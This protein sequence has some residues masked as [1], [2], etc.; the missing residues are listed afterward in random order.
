MPIFPQD[1]TFST[2]ADGGDLVVDDIVVGLRNGLNTRFQF[3]GEPGTYLPL[4]GGTMAGAIDMNGNIITGLPAPVSATDAVNKAYADSL[5]AGAAM[6]KVDDTNVT[7]TLGGTPLTSLLHAVSLTLGWAGQLSFAR[8]G[9]NA[10][11]TAS[12]GGIL[13]STA[14]AAAILAGTATARQML[15]SG[16]TAAPAWSTATWPATTTANAILFSSATNIVSEI[17]SAA[18]GVLITSAGSVPSISQTLPSAVQTNI[19]ALGAQSQALN[20]NSHLINNVTDPVSAQDAATKNY[21]DK[22]ALNGT[23]VYAATTTNLTVTQSGAGVGATLTN[24]GAQATF[25][26]DGVNPPVGS[27]VLIKNLAAPANEGIYT[28]TSV[29]SGSTNWVLTR[30]TSYDT[31]T[32]INNTGLIIIQNGSTLAGTAWYNATTIVTVDTTAFSYSQF[33]NIIFPVSLAQGGTGASLTASNG[34]IFYSTASAGAILAGTATAGK[35][36]Q[37]GATAA[38]SWST[39]T[40]PSA[41]GTSGK[42]LASDGTNIVYSTA[43]FPVVGGAAGNVLISNGTNYV[44]ST[45]LWPNTV[46]T[47]GT[48]IKSNGTNNVY[49]TSTYSDSYAASALLYAS[50]ANTVVGLATA[51]NGTLVT[52]GSGVPSISSTLP[53]AVITNIPGRLKSFQTFTT[54]SGTYTRPA[55]ISSILVEC[56]GGGAGGGGITAA[57][58]TIAVASGGGGGGYCRKWYSA[59]ASS[60]SYAVGAG[61]AGGVGATNGTNGGNSTFDVMTGGGGNGGALAGGIVA[62]AVGITLGGGGGVATGGDLNSPGGSG[63]NGLNI[64]TQTAAGV[65]GASFWGHQSANQGAT[66][67]NGSTSRPYGGGGG[68]ALG[69]LAG[70]TTQNGAVGADGVIIVWEFS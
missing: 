29:G 33:G 11:L 19:T 62:S 32:E 61:G 31:A 22:T 46:G 23:S 44:A 59:A 58:T 30:A 25:A 13:Y 34:G 15:Q 6:S 54:G 57:A 48:V 10:S 65:G 60:Y 3:K 52:D 67:A 47:N 42:I 38:P 70:G 26:L 50:S 35:V 66:T 53:S 43:T 55:G 64:T 40:Y 9:T 17:V 16:A 69:G 1:A 21:V 5:V 12:N 39:P 37:S 56:Q 68:G 8:G 27:N 14:T 45:S 49:S 36:L 51:N 28:V 24:A 18:S 4:A 41:S 63:G 20:M 7:L 2:F